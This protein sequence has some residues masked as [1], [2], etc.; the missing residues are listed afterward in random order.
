MTHLIAAKTAQLLEAFAL[1]YL[2]S[3]NGSF[4]QRTAADRRPASSAA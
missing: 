2:Q 1:S 4:E 3:A